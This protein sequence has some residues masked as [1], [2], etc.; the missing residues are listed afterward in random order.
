MVTR[1]KQVKLKRRIKRYGDGCYAVV[2]GRRRGPC[3]HDMGTASRRF[4]RSGLIASAKTDRPR[5]TVERSPLS[6][7]RS[8]NNHRGK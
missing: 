5:R 4:R 8:P 3:A 1:R 6:G 2:I 7:Q